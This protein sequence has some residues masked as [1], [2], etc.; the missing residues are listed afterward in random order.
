[1]LDPL[2][3]QRRKNLKQLEEV[4]GRDFEQF[5]NHGYLTTFEF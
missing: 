5:K 2:V 4:L 1:M 3:N